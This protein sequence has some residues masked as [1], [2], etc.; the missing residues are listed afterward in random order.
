MPSPPSTA[1][2]NATGRHPAGAGQAQGTSQPRFGAGHLRYRLTVA[3]V[4][5]V[6]L[7]WPLW[8]PQREASAR[9]LAN[10]ALVDQGT[11]EMRQPEVQWSV[12]GSTTWQ[13]VLSRQAVSAGDRVRT[14]PSAAARLVY[15]EGTVTEIGPETGFLVERLERSQDSNIVSRLYQTAGTTLSYVVHLVDPAASFEVE[16]PAVTVFV[17]GTTPRV[18]V[19]ESTGFTRVRNVPDGTASRVGVIGKDA[20]QTTV[21]LQPGEQTE[22]IPGSPPSPPTR[23]NVPVVQPTRG[24]VAPLTM[25]DPCQWPGASCDWRLPDPQP[26]DPCQRPNDICNPPSPLPTLVTCQPGG[27]S[28]EPR[29]PDVCPIPALCN[30]PGDQGPTQPRPTATATP[31][32]P[33]ATPTVARPS[34]TPTLSLP[35]ATPTLARPTAT[36]TPTDPCQRP[37]VICDPAPSNPCRQLPRLCST[38]TGSEPSPPLP[39]AT[40]T[41]TPPLGDG[42]ILIQPPR[43]PVQDRATPSVVLLPTPSSDGPP[44]SGPIRVTTSDHT[45]P[46]GQVPSPLSDTSILTVPTRLALPDRVSPSV[47]LIPTRDPGPR[48]N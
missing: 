48:I 11:L 39:T 2:L 5:L 7:V 32:R 8:G 21:I 3:L 31:P 24:P 45:L 35:T 20:N 1:L 25:P 30:S 6:S 42:P 27:I 34:A 4:L 26:S 38:P 23:W 13:A 43:I 36:S 10:D 37:G 15:F 17:R 44:R 14:G 18:D 46:S 9:P 40:Q 16:T 19:T 28:C 29:F 33:S 12:R 22:V 41:R 47:P